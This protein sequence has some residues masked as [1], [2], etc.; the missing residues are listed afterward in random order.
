M[1][2]EETIGQDVLG[3]AGGYSRMPEKKKKELQK[4]LAEELRKK[5]EEEERRKREEELEKLP[6]ESIPGE[7]PGDLT[8][9][10]RAELQ[11]RG[12][13]TGEQLEA[14]EKKTV[15]VKKH[16]RR[17]PKKKEKFEEIF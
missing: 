2:E 6:K 8:P 15:A 11:Q 5:R 9:R 4:Q 1:S 16:K 10:Q 13:L 14:E 3:G 17:P 7:I 12:V